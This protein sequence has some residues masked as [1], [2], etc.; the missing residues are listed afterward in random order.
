M[1]EQ[2]NGIHSAEDTHLLLLVIQFSRETFESSHCIL[3]WFSLVKYQNEIHHNELQAH[4][5]PCSTLKTDPFSCY[6]G[7][8]FV[9]LVLVFTS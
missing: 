7:L 4:L 8:H 1:G 3:I 5:S 2:M 9:S 6:D